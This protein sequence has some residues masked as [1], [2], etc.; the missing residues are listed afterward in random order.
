MYTKL[1]T[2]MNQHIK[3]NMLEFSLVKMSSSVKRYAKGDVIHHL[4]D[5]MES[6]YF[7]NSGLLRGFSLDENGK[8]YTWSIFF[9]DAN[10]RTENLFA[11]D[12]ES[13]VNQ[14]PSRLEIEVLEDCE[15]ITFSYKNL[16][17]LYDKSSKV[18]FFAKMM[19]DNAYCYL[20]NLVIDRQT[21]SAARRFEEFMRNTPHLLDKVP[22]YHIATFL[23]I[24]P[25]H[26]SR[27][28]KQ[29]KN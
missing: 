9:N 18:Q 19:A 3:L 15:L 10:A 28:K 2:Y 26:L 22:Q 1:Q 6:L 13:F 20:H 27:L 12:Y 17:M 25:Q 14:T 8:D 11:V 5:V 21:K 23:D 4:G 7:V 16:M 24:T 29:Y